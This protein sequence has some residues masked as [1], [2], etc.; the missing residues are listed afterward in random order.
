MTRPEVKAAFEGTPTD[1][2]GPDSAEPTFALS[3]VGMLV[4]GLAL[5]AIAILLL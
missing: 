3:L 2:R 1:R 5:L 4:L